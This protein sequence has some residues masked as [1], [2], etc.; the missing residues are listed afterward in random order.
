MR[1]LLV[2]DDAPLRRSIARGLREAGFRVDEAGNGRVAL[3]LAAERPYGALVLDILLPE[4]D[5]VEVCRR[6]RA[7]NDW[8]PILILTAL[9]AVEQRIAGLDAGA[10]DYLGKPFDF[11]ELLARL[12]ALLR[13]RSGR[14]PL[15]AAVGDLH[16]D[17][18]RRTAYRGD[19][20][21]D[22]TARE[23]DLLVFLARRQG[24]VITRAELLE[25]VWGDPSHTHSNVVD[26]YMSRLRR[27]VDEGEATPLLG[28]RRGV[29]YF[30][31]APLASGGG[32]HREAPPSREGTLAA[33]EPGERVSEPPPLD[34]ASPGAGAAWPEEA[35][36]GGGPSTPPPRFGGR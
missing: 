9:D 3:A 24:E 30:L 29:G 26:V 7:G 4:M 36:G 2:E 6:L 20:R 8:T 25:A 32:R 11:G 17:L 16:L 33:P 1:I 23:F 5:G 15:E 12:R 14:A 35:E 21:L 31:E 28:T 22:L 13:R 19:R 10:D 27:K 18:R 34:E